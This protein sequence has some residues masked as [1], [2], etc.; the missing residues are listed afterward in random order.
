MHKKR[1]LESEHTHNASAVSFQDLDTRVCISWGSSSHPFAVC[2]CVWVWTDM[3]QVCW[4][5]WP[6]SCHLIGWETGFYVSWP[7]P[8]VSSS[9]SHTCRAT[10]AA[11]AALC[12]IRKKLWSNFLHFQLKLCV[13]VNCVGFSQGLAFWLVAAV[14]SRQWEDRLVPRQ[15]HNQTTNCQKTIFV[16]H[17]M[18]PLP[19]EHVPGNVPCVFFSSFF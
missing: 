8:L 15:F 18:E 11:A 3:L 16:W 14:N 1:R 19:V 9:S 10:A 4:P 6:G 13:F 17:K 7:W 12:L 5:M 2:V